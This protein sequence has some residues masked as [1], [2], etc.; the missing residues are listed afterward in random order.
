MIQWSGTKT[1]AVLAISARENELLEARLKDGQLSCISQQSV[2]LH[3]FKRFI[4]GISL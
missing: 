2:A 1:I 4:T 3:Q